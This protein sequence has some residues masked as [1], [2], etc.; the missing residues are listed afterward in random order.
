MEEGPWH[1][2]ETVL[3]L[4]RAGI[5]TELVLPGA[6][7][8]TSS[9]GIR[10]RT[11]GRSLPKNRMVLGS[12]DT[13]AEALE[14]ACDKARAGRWEPLDW[15]ARPWAKSDGGGASLASRWGL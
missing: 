1:L 12:G 6:S 8:D 3:S 4:Y 2:E 7:E 15:S 9:V 13:F 11:F 10:L 5:S 14:V